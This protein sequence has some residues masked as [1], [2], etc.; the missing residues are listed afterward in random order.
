[1]FHKAASNDMFTE[2][3]TKAVQRKG[4]IVLRIMIV[5]LLYT[6]HT[7]ACCQT[8]GIVPENKDFVF[9]YDRLYQGFY[10]GVWLCEG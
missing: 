5:S 6:E 4:S 8:D 3:T 2:L 10:L 7:L 1:M 9:K